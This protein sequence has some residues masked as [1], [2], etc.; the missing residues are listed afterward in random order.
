LA[1]FVRDAR[2]QG[3]PDTAL[4]AQ[5][6]HG[7]TRYRTRVR[8]WYLRADRTIAVGADGEFYLLSVPSSLRA[9]IAGAQLSPDEPRLIIGEGARDGE[10]MPLAVLLRQRLDAGKNWPPP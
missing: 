10:S 4:T 5:A 2:A 8:G 9:L 1:D 6:Y 3:L 7:R